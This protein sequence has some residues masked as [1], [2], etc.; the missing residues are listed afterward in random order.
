MPPGPL[1]VDTNVFSFLLYRKGPWQDFADIVS[2]HPLAVSFATYGE[3]LAH[4]Y[5]KG[6]PVNRLA[7]IRVALAQFVVLPYDSRVADLWAPLYGKLHGH[8]K[9][10]GVNDIWTAGC[11]LAQTP[12]LPIVTDDLADFGLIESE[13]PDLVLLHPSFI[14]LSQ[15]VEV[16]GSQ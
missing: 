6:L 16:G 11:A 15:Q 10:Q 3:A 14:D 2:G 4:G 9:G 5:Q 12:S 8:M 1:V 7:K 13:R